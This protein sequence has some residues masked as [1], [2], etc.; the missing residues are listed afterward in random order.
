V[1]VRGAPPLDPAEAARRAATDSDPIWLSSCGPSRDR[2]VGA[3]FDVVACQPSVVFRGGSIAALERCWVQARRAWMATGAAPSSEIPV[4]VGWLS[5]DLARQWI[6]LAPRARD[7]H[8]W[9]EIEF[10]F[11]DA[12]WIREVGA[13]EA[14]IVAV[15]ETAADRLADTLRRGPSR[16]DPPELGPL[17]ADD[18]RAN[19]GQAVARI[20]EYLRAGDAY[21]VNLARRMTATVGDGDPVWM[22]AA[23]RA[24]APAPHAIWLAGRSVSGGRIDRQIVGNS[25]ERFLRVDPDGAVETRPIK[26]TR[27]RGT[28]LASD[29]GA[30]AEL[31]AAIK[32]RAEHVMIVD[33]ERN[34][35]GRVCETGS[36]TV[37]GLLRI[38]ELPTLFHLV[39]TV[40][41][42][43]R[44]GVGLEE[45]LRATFPGGS[46]TGAPKR[47]AMEIIE[48]LEPVRRGIYT[49][50]TGWLG[51]AGDLDLAIAIRTA[52]IDANRLSLS[53][54]GGIV[55]DS[56]AADEWEET[57]VKAAAFLALCGPLS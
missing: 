40:H 9:P 39:S 32:D 46:V 28:D 16:L 26:G 37:E 48:E 57:E 18:P 52:V 21:Q 2:D 29:A 19:H 6:P 42:R 43:L 25:P 35:L 24:R 10:R 27:P 11:F 55:A 8:G 22:A 36:V 49:G 54:G 23:L 15:G 4:G 33:L 20:K 50:A 41:G 14:R 12:V 47:R 56:D 51:A 30:R 1:I 7:D 45:L 17:K 13:A 44:P 31:A 53:V 5:Y 34:D 38:V 3:T